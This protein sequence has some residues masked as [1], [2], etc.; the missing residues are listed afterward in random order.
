MVISGCEASAPASD[1]TLEPGT[2]HAQSLLPMPLKSEPGLVPGILLSD[3][4]IV[5]NGTGKRT[6]VGCFDQMAFPK[7]PATYGPIWITAWITNLVGTLAEMELTCRDQEKSGHVLHSA[8]VKIQFQSETPFDTTSTI[9]FS[10]PIKQITF[11]GKG[12][13]TVMVLLNGEEAGHRDF[14]VLEPQPKP[15]P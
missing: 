9:A 12:I 15:N 1:F 10:T 5:E 6:I 4:S 8:N 3:L 2:S 13:Y 7:F 14:N 11:P